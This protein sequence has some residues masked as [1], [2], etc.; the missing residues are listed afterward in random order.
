[1]RSE[2][3]LDLLDSAG[4]TGKSSGD[5]I[6]SRIP[7][8]GLSPEDIQSLK[9]QG[10]PV[11]ALA[12]ETTDKA[13]VNLHRYQNVTSNSILSSLHACPRRFIQEK[14]QAAD[15]NASGVD[16]TP[17]IDFVFGHSVGAG[18]AS[19]LAFDRN[20]DY[21][22][23]AAF[24]SWY[25]SWELGREDYN[26]RKKKNIERAAM[27]VIKFHHY[28]GATHDEWEIYRLADGR[29]AVEVSF[30]VDFGKYKYFGHIDLVLRNK[31]TG[32]IAIGE[33]KTTGY[34]NP[35]PAVYQNSGQAIGYAVVLDRIVGEL[36]DYDVLYYAYS[37][38]GEEWHHFPF[39]KTAAMK[40]EWVQDRLIDHGHVEQYFKLQHFPKN[41]A[42][43]FQ[44]NRPCPFF[45]DCDLLD[46]QRLENLAVLD[47]VSGDYPVDF[48]VNVQDV[49]QQQAMK[50][51]A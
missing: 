37:A 34:V 28:W 51:L 25:G 6:T 2:D 38:S 20:L 18:I 5:G 19:Y 49:I 33:N 7:L 21:G 23:Y 41:G 10:N 8:P 45:G 11:A 13:Y 42:S 4:D 47:D 22:L 9:L 27:A 15:R 43:C 36:A 46:R 50:G 32:R 12:I 24:L 29:P 3:I 35:H 26:E 48:Y 16:R 44:F 14:I 1:M 31:R 39:A 17:N 30:C 40:L